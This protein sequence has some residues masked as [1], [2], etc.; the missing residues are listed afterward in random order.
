MLHAWLKRIII[1][2]CIDE[3]RKN[4]ITPE[5]SGIPDWV[6]EV[7]DNSQNADHTL[8]FSEL[9]RYVKN[10]PPVYRIVFNMFVMDGCT[11]VEIANHL[12]IAVGTSKSNLARARSILQKCIDKNEQFI[13]R[14]ADF[15][16][17][18]FREPSD[19]VDFRDISELRNH[20]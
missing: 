19:N 20:F 3:L 8:L 4:K 2:T 16:F 9:I 18:A 11:H 5:I 6:F 10:L 14:N 12:G 17:L 15:M 1:N 7:T 13:S